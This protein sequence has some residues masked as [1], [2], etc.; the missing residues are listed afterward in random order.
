MSPLK[1]SNFLCLSQTKPALQLRPRSRLIFAFCVICSIRIHRSPRSR[2]A[3]QIFYSIDVLFLCLIFILLLAIILIL[4][5]VFLGLL[6][7][8]QA[9]FLFLLGVIVIFLLLMPLLSTRRTP[10]NPLHPLHL[11]YRALLVIYLCFLDSPGLVTDPR[12]RL[13]P[14]PLPSLHL[15]KRL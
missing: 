15:R 4:L 13:P 6:L 10:L 1:Q 11:T 7:I 14:L 12:P 3:I 9:R 8:L 2:I 5:L